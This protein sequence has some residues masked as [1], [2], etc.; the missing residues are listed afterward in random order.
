MLKRSVVRGRTG[1][2]PA[3]ILRNPQSSAESCQ[4]LPNSTG[5]GQSLAGFLKSTYK[6]MENSR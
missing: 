5:L 4:A 1:Q 2:S 6:I 3:E